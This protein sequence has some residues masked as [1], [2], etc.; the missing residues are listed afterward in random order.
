MTSVVGAASNFS[1][2]TITGESP[3]SLHYSLLHDAVLAG[4]WRNMLMSGGGRPPEPFVKTEFPRPEGSLSAMG[5]SFKHASPLVIKPEPSTMPVGM[6]SPL[7]SR[8]YPMF[9]MITP[10]SKHME[11]QGAPLAAMAMGL[12]HH[13]HPFMI[14]PE[15]MQSP[16]TQVQSPPGSFMPH[17]QSE[18]PPPPPRVYKPCVVCQDKS[19]GYH[20]G[21]SSCE[22]CKVCH[23][24]CLLLCIVHL[25]HSSS[26]FLSTECAE[27]YGLHLPQREKLC[28]KQDN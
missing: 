20:Y 23:Y 5:S 25:R 26:G 21:V 14:H 8:E 19:S 2:N 24:L 11:M 1:S 7:E 6:P 27:K 28:D 12:Q 22:G 4:M 10:D 3:P 17:G 15:K 18:S 16:Q 9:P 13:N